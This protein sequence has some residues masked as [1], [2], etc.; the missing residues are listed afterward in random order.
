[1]TYHRGDTVLWLKQQKRLQKTMGRVCNLKTFEQEF[2]GKQSRNG[3]TLFLQPSDL[4]MRSTEDLRSCHG[5]AEVKDRWHARA[6]L[7]WN[8]QARWERVVTF[9]IHEMVHVA[10][11]KII[12]LNKNMPDYYREKHG[13]AEGLKVWRR[14]WQ[15]H[16]QPFKG[17]VRSAYQEFYSIK[18]AAMTE[19]FAVYNEAVKV[20]SRYRKK[21][22]SRYSFATNAYVMDILVEGYLVHKRSGN[23]ARLAGNKSSVIGKA[24]AKLKADGNPCGVLG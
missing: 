3:H 7:F 24:L 20:N 11:F 9:A 22:G 12:V 14:E 5:Y 16:G 6:F 18:P 23:R 13:E 17:L 15:G 2:R 19:L 21:Y 1:M 10:I 8:D 4:H